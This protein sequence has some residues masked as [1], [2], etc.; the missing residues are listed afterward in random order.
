MEKFKESLTP[1]QKITKAVEQL[2]QPWIKSGLELPRTS[3]LELSRI[4]KLA[5]FVVFS[6]IAEGRVIINGQTPP[7]KAITEGPLSPKEVRQAQWGPYY[8]RVAAEIQ[9]E[10]QRWQRR[11]Q[12]PPA[13]AKGKPTRNR[14]E[15]RVIEEQIRRVKV[16]FEPYR[17]P[18]EVEREAKKQRLALRWMKKSAPETPLSPSQAVIATV[19]NEAMFPTQNLAELKR[20]VDQAIQANRPLRIGCFVCLVNQW[21]INADNQPTYQV[22]DDSQQLTRLEQPPFIQRS[23]QLFAALNNLGLPYQWDFLIADTD[24][25]ELYSQWV[26]SSDEDKLRIKKFESRIK[27]KLCQLSPETVNTR[28]WSEIQGKYTQQYQ[29]DFKQVLNG[30]VPIPNFAE[31]Y[32]ERVKYYR[33]FYTNFYAQLGLAV[34]TR[35]IEALATIPPRLN[36]ALYA[37]QGPIV[38]TE[39][40]LLVIGDRD[41]LRCGR[42]QSL[43]VKDL[44]IWY[45]FSGA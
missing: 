17:D 25:E 32:A 27:D 16:D 41:P 2:A 30:E 44:P 4:T 7:Q 8:Q 18:V 36:L 12:L 37:A 5:P 10:G 42:N 21:N 19:Q 29:E 15:A 23:K 1:D 11:E 9:G 14:I 43:L 45:P 39:Y 26:Q 31:V 6:N 28:L 34:N 38:N 3:V 33:Q 13:Y 40:D 22:N 20:R 35:D 24:A